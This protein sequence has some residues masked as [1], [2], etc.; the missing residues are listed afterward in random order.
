MECPRAR[1]D[2]EF[3]PLTHEGRPMILVRDRLGLVA[4][5]LG[6]SAGLMPV[7]R[8]LDGQR[9]VAEVAGEL[10]RLRGG[11][12]VSPQNLSELLAELDGAGLLVSPRYLARK[13]AVADAF[14]AAPAREPAFA[15]L[16]YPAAPEALR[17]FLDDILAAAPADVSV[18]SASAPAAVVAP[19]LD[20]EAGRPGYA[21][22]YAALAGRRYRRVVVLG[23][24]HQLMDGLF[25]LTDKPFATPLGP[26]PTDGAAVAALRAAGGAAVVGDGLPHRAEHSVE[27]QAVFLRH[28]LADGFS[29]VPVLCG[30]PVGCLDGLSRPAFRRVAGPFLDALA[31]LAAAD[32]TLVV[33][34]VDM[35]HIGLK[36]GHDRPAEALEAAALAHD[37]AL[38]DRLCA[39]D[40]EG[41]WAESARV[42]DGYNVC[43]LTALAALAEVLPGVR[44]RVLCHDLLRE[45]PTQSA[46]TFAAAVFP[47]P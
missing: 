10:T 17:R 36:F 15:G 30:S 29:L 47:R 40:P 12:E 23:V 45:A 21:A 14:A 34:G 44:G 24:G 20:P 46:V 32:D 25:C 26:V 41:F 9:S 8:L 3:I 2:L 42:A 33:A 7:L 19:H 28:V 31:A 38:L 4:E 6:F 1:Q 27:F 39:G 11:I 18:D 37:R 5:G 13:A 43:G 22:A 16:A 35:C